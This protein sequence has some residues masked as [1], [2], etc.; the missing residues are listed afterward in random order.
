MK[1]KNYPKKYIYAINLY[2][3]RNNVPDVLQTKNITR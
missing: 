2:I 3:K 1:T